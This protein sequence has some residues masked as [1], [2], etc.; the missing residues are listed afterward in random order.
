MQELPDPVSKL[1]W[2]S[3]LEINPLTAAAR[4]LVNGDVVSVTSPHGA[5]EVPVW[6]Y[7]GIRED[8]VALAMGNGHTASGR[9]A[10]GNGVNA[11]D[12]LP[13]EAEQPSGGMLTVATT[14]TLEPTGARMRLA[15]VDGSNGDQHDRPIAPAI[16]L[17]VLAEG[18]AEEEPHEPHMELQA[19]GGFIPVPSTGA[20]EDFPPAGTEYGMYAGAREGPRWAMAIDLDKCTGC[21]ACVIACQAE[22]NVPWTGEE[23]V[24]MGRDMAWIR[25][26]RYYE[27]VDAAQASDLDVRFLPMLCQHCNNAPCEPVCPVFATY[28]TPEGVNAQVYNRCVGTRYCANN[29]P[30]KVR[31]FNWYRYTGA[32]PEPLNWQW[33]PDVTV[34]DNGVMEKCSF[35]MQRIRETENRAALEG[36]RP[37]SDGEIVPA[38]EQ[39][40]PAEAIVFGNIR[41]TSSRV[42]Q[43]VASERTYRVLDALI[44]TQPAVSYLEKVT[45]HEV[46]AAA[47]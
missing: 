39:S 1:V 34:R 4:G 18:V 47:H 43:A 3:W 22:N 42:A 2:H 17:A 45:F 10:D 19:G 9:Y 28:H 35:C 29:C 6:L 26:E 5:V 14:V 31:V 36:G 15:S 8:A 32:I 12:L 16:Q 11:L 7:P 44:N 33:N 13:A 41:D 40:C 20:V 24:R 37:I 23:Q 38:C 21:S 30:Y 27:H 25:I 46:A